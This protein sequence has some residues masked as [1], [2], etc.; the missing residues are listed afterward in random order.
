MAGYGGADDHIEATQNHIDDSLALNKAMADVADNDS[1]MCEECG[2]QIDEAR[3]K[4]IPKC[5]RC[6]Y[7]QRAYE[8]ERKQFN[9]IK[10]RNVYMP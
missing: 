10:C 2:D 9:T 4:A 5:K 1:G 6:I 3:I 8:L 7:C